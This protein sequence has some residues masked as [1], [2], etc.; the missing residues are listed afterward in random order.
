ME[1]VR[2]LEQSM[3]RAMEDP[4]HVKRAKDI[5][6]DLVFMSAE[7]YGKFLTEQD[8][9]ARPLISLYRK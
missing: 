8:D 5:G 2:Y 1:I 4:E 3:K 9:W 7:E 6:L